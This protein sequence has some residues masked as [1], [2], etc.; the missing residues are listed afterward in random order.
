MSHGG[1]MCFRSGGEIL[2]SAN[3]NSCLAPKNPISS[4]LGRSH[5]LARGCSQERPAND[6]AEQGC[7]A[8]DRRRSCVQR[9][10]PISPCRSS[11][12]RSARWRHGAFFMA[13]TTDSW[14]S[15]TSEPVQAHDS[16]WNYAANGWQRSPCCSRILRVTSEIVSREPPRSVLDAKEG[17]EDSLAVV[18]AEAASSIAI[19]ARSGSRASTTEL[20]LAIPTHW[21]VDARTTSVAR[22]GDVASIATGA[23]SWSTEA[24][25]SAYG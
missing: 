14:F 1:R 18:R 12:S 10:A 7:P 24:R 4:W 17:R 2:R 6:R 13:P 5:D 21:A 16:D 19:S 9:L 3:Q 20:H 22:L 25:A 8:S 15:P 23:D 11:G